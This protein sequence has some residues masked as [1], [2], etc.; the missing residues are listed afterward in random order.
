MQHQLD[1]KK[2]LGDICRFAPS[3]GEG[4]FENL[5]RI[6]QPFI[7]KDFSVHWPAFGLWDLDYL[8]K[9][10]GDSKIWVRDGLGVK[11]TIETISFR[12]FAGYIKDTAINTASQNLYLVLSRIMSHPK[13]R[14][15]Q[16]PGL[17]QDIILPSF[18][19][20]NRLWEINLWVGAC[21]N[22]SKLHFD[23]EENLLVPIRGVKKLI[24]IKRSETPNVYQNLEGNI[25]ESKVDVFN[26]DRRAF[27]KI[28]AV[29]YHQ[30][31]LEPGEALYI[32]SG[33][34]HAVESSIEV[35]ISLNFWWLPNMSFLVKS[36]T[37]RRLWQ[38]REKWMS[39]CTL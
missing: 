21:G 32:P 7:I 9:K 13:A 5:L 2:S 16:L 6:H 27:P 23:P 3:N 36:P 30:I 33:W 37:Y 19:P 28:D 14:T 17:L 4:V 20:I 34:W 18:I 38:K 26:L 39:V 1:P 12:K 10:E 8:I 22:R 24:L 35:N 11:Q 29:S 31:T 25:L 15:V